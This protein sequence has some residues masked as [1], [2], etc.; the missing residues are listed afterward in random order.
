MRQ[1]KLVRPDLTKSILGTAYTGNMPENKYLEFLD[2]IKSGKKLNMGIEG[3]IRKY[4]ISNNDII[5]IK[6]DLLAEEK[7]GINESPVNIVINRFIPVEEPNLSDIEERLKGITEIHSAE[8]R[9]VGE[10]VSFKEG[11]IYLIEN[12]AWPGMVKAGMTIDYVSR[13]VTYNI[14]DPHAAF[15]YISVKW[16]KDRRIAEIEL[17]NI[18]RNNSSY[19]RGEWFKI[20]KEF[21]L[22][23]LNDL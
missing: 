8:I 10:Q 23:K 11:F 2:I 5:R 17:L 12:P 4:K 1:H 7:L 3:I 6:K 13:L 18:L 20:D 19:I 22:L 16:V 15:S 9:K 21:A 14:S